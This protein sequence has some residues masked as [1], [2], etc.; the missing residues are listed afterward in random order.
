MFACEEICKLSTEQLKPRL[1]YHK[2]IVSLLQS[3]LTA[4]SVKKTHE[5][6]NIDGHRATVSK[7]VRHKASGLNPDQK[8]MKTMFEQAIK[9]GLSM[10][11]F[12]D[13]IKGQEKVQ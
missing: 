9:M 1:E 10:E 12:F 13:L 8:K 7:S 6:H 11:Q 4:R 5:V 2:A 3:E